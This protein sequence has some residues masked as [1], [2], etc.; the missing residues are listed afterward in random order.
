MASKFYVVWAGRET[1]IYLMEI[2]K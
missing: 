1:G 2:K